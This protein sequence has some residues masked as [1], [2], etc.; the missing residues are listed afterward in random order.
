MGLDFGER[1]GE[2][3]L[4]AGE[5]RGDSLVGGALAG[6]RQ[7]LGVAVGN[8]EA[9]PGEAENGRESHSQAPPLHGISRLKL[10]ANSVPWRG[11]RRG[12]G[13]L[14]ENSW[15]RPSPPPGHPYQ[16]TPV[17][18]WE[19][20][21]AGTDTKNARTRIFE[22]PLRHQAVPARLGDEEPG[23]GGVGLD[24]LAQ[25]VDVGFEGV[26]RDPGVVAPDPVQKHLAADG[27]AA[28]TVEKLENRGL[29]FGETDFPPGFVV[30]EELVGGP[31]SIGTDGELGVFGMLVL[32]Q[33]G[34]RA[35]QQDPEAEGLGDVIVGAGF[36]TENRVGV[37]VRGGQHDDRHVVAHAPG[38]PANLAPIHVGKPDVEQD[39]VEAVVLHGL[40]GLASRRRFGDGEV[41]VKMKLLGERTA[42]WGV[43]IDNQNAFFSHCWVFLVGVPMALLPHQFLYIPDPSEAHS[44][45][46]GG[47]RFRARL[48]APSG[49]ANFRDYSQFDR[50]LLPTRAKNASPDHGTRAGK[51][52]NSAL[53]GG[54][55][56]AR[57]LL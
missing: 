10:A 2:I 28:G 51:G 56:L 3:V 32:S 15:H 4:V 5:K 31:K 7:V 21:R 55:R 30:D 49:P 42:Q 45:F 12:D 1:G 50:Q 18:G 52:R 13:P 27:L 29:F 16:H 26:G 8:E 44:R 22:Q 48:D 47:T 36:E 19:G 17:G 57:V 11:A 39:Q 33:L 43:V 53:P 41:L 46:C 35:G 14:F 20:E 9:A 23:A 24:L 37:A 40:D 38:Q 6:A 34:P 25:A 54:F